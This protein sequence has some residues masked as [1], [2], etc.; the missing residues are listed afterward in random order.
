MGFEDNKAT[1]F[2]GGRGKGKTDF[3]KEI[4]KNN[5]LPKTLIVDTFDN[6]RWR[7]ME[8]WN[9]PE[10]AKENVPIIKPEHIKYWKKGIY[11]VFD[12]D[13]EKIKNTIANDLLNCLLIWEDAS[14]YYGKSLSKDELRIHY[15]T[16]QRNINSIYVFHSLRKATVEIVENSDLLT[17]KKTGDNINT[18]DRKYQNPDINALFTE[19]SKHPD[20][21]CTETIFIN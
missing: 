7:T 1:T 14:K 5:P 6:E 12:S 15:D 9:H 10:W 19:V 17:L 16:K 20:K 21:Y 13:L 8:T 4:A 18:I 11:R 3:L 2:C